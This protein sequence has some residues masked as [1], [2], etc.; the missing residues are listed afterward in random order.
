MQRALDDITPSKRAGNVNFL[1]RE[2]IRSNSPVQA[3]L[4]ATALTHG[5]SARGGE[6]KRRLLYR[7]I[8]ERPFSCN[9]KAINW[10]YSAC[11][12]WTKLWL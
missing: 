2:A 9:Q 11:V 1:S 3:T 4:K 6:V 10:T 12:E 8:P 5:A 7:V